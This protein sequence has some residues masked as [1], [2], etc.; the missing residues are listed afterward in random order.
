MYLAGAVTP[1]GKGRIDRPF[2]L[3]AYRHYI[4]FLKEGRVPP[5]NLYRHIFS[6]VLTYSAD[7][8]YAIPIAQDR[9]LVRIA[10]PVVQMQP[11]SMDYSVYDGKFRPMV[12]GAESILWGIQFT[13]PQ[14]YQEATTK[15][16][17]KV[18]ENA[19]LP[20]NRLFHQLQRWMR[21]HTIPTPFM[22]GNK[23]TNVS[24]RLGKECTKWI[25]HHPQLV[26][27]GIKVVAHVD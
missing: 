23:K 11:H 4:E 26:L 25:N 8:L 27:K 21:T 20:N 16:V 12:L 22:V 5:E 15:E 9:Q 17:V 13:Y 2:F 24:M 1:L 19:A 3:A 6:S 14:L 18:K 10:K 7:H